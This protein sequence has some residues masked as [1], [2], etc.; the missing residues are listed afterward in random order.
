MTSPLSPLY[1]EHCHI[2]PQVFAHLEWFS[3]GASVAD[4]M[5]AIQR[6]VDIKPVDEDAATRTT[7]AV[8][9]TPDSSIAIY[10]VD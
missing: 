6:E 1:E 5:P 2:D 4:R 3:A 9:L 10:F 8:D 7:L